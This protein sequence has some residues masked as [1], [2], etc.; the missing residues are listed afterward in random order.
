MV[1]YY[2]T[3]G[4][5]QSLAEKELAGLKAAG[6]DA[7]IFQIP[8]TLPQEVLDKMHAPAKPT[9]IPVITTHDLTEFDGFL[10]GFSTRF[11]T[12]PAQFKA[13]WDATGGLWANG[14]L[15][16]K[17]FG[18]FVSTGSPNGGQEVSIRNSLSNFVHHGLIYV[19]LGYKHAF[20]Q[21]SNLEEVHGGSPWGAGAYAGGD[22]SRQFSDLE[23]EIGFIQGKTFAETVIK[24]HG[25]AKPAAS[26]ESP[27]VATK[28]DDIEA[29]TATSTES[30]ATKIEKE[31]V[32]EK[33]AVAEEAAPA[34]KA[35]PAVAPAAETKAAAPRVA[36]Q[37]V[38]TA[39]KKQESKKFCGICTIM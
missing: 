22:G 19:P 33:E 32:A 26:T 10:F 38:D 30:P 4:H 34:E 5:T 25:G 1:I 6:V 15:H 21:L 7:Q 17:Y 36:Q 35:V 20:G 23:L 29:T 27:N 3:Y 2:S 9:D 31:V 12:Y 39:P 24:A 14:T 28:T 8:E 13:F 18:I 37:Q 16:G 11:G